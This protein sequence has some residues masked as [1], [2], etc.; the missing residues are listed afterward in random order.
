L[1]GAFSDFLIAQ[2]GTT[3]LTEVPECLVLRTLLMAGPKTVQF[4]IKQ[5]ALINDFKDYYL[6]HN[7]PV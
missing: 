4:L 7:L 6:Q 3:I 2:G 1:V 5:S